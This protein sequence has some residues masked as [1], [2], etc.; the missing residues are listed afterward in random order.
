MATVSIANTSANIS[1]KT[2]ITAERDNTIT[3]AITFNRGANPPFII[4]A[5]ATLVSNLIVDA[6][7]IGGTGTVPT[8]RLG[9]GVADSTVFLSGASTWIASTGLDYVQL[10][11]FVT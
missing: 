6:A 11:S 1:G 2:M 5:T 7:V 10:Q 9:T 3:G 8:A 4:N